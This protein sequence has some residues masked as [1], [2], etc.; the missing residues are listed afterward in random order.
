MMCGRRVS[1]PDSISAAIRCGNR[2]RRSGAGNGN[3]IDVDVRGPRIFP[4]PVL[5]F[6]RELGSV[7]ENAYPRSPRTA[8]RNVGL[9]RV[10][11]SRSGSSRRHDEEV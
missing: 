10:V 1:R 6:E 8:G 5:G 3:R 7:G 4:A 11:R 9:E 2:G